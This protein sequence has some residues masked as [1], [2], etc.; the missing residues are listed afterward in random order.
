MTPPSPAVEMATMQVSRMYSK[1]TD[2]ADIAGE[3]LKENSNQELLDELSSERTG[4]P[5]DGMQEQAGHGSLDDSFVERIKSRSPA[6]RHSRIE[7]SVEAL[8]ALEDAIEKVDE[9][10][11]ATASD[12]SSPA[13]R[14][15]PKVRAEK[16]AS[17]TSKASTAKTKSLDKKSSAPMPTRTKSGKTQKSLN[18]SS[19][20]NPLSP[21]REIKDTTSTNS[22]PRKPH[23]TRTPK[24][25]SSIHKT[26]FQPSKSTKPITKSTFELPGD[27][28]ARKLKEQREER[29]KREEESQSKARE[30]KAKPFRTSQ[31]PEVKLTAITR[32][33]LSLAQQP[34]PAKT[35]KS[36]SAPRG[37]IAPA[38][39]PGAR[40]PVSDNKAQGGNHMHVARPILPSSANTS[41]K[42]GPSLSSSMV[43]RQPSTASQHRPAPTTGEVSQQKL[44]GKE[45]FGRTKVLLSEKEKEKKTKEEAAR[46]ARVDA[47][48]RGRLASREWAEK[49]KAK[50]LASQKGSGSPNGK[51][52]AV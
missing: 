2:Q 23:E 5:K 10:I 28:V 6:K 11:P 38:A 49:Q 24:R 12:R 42:R 39:A 50:K 51:A 19:T 8:D 9:A 25:V 22:A 31:A 44:R 35:T 4:D 32:A 47:A 41:A 21:Q 13:D 1:D 26:P 18:P 37:S 3:S 29:Q 17:K 33:R 43:S 52:A 40:K 15:K 46:K 36:S 30:F 16:P 48:E 34:A 14:R 45:V 7:D 20:T 27:A